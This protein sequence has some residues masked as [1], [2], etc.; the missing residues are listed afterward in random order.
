MKQQAATDS[1][2]PEFALSDPRSNGVWRYGEHFS[3]HEQRQQLRNV[4]RHHAPRCLRRC[5]T[6]RVGMCHVLPTFSASS[7]PAQI[8]SYTNLIET[9]ISLAASL[10]VRK[11]HL[12]IFCLRL[13]MI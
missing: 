10:T 7:F 11:C 6:A 3:E 13:R 9:F 8:R 2:G 4:V 5:S 1:H 12:F